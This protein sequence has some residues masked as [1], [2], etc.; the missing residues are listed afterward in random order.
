MQDPRVSAEPSV[1]EKGSSQLRPEVRSRP[2]PPL[3]CTNLIP[4][5]QAPQLLPVSVTAET[6]RRWGRRGVG[7]QQLPLVKIGG[8]L[9]VRP[10]DLAAFVQV[11][12]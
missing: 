7:G 12:Q 2:V 5:D 4:V 6:I 11:S 8:R 10:S 3:T 9:F 1:V